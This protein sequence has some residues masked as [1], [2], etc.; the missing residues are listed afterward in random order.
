MALKLGLAILVAGAM[1]VGPSVAQT[2]PTIVGHWHPEDTPQDC[3]TPFE[4]QITPMGYAEETL[5]C[6]FDDVRRD[7][8]QVT[9]NG[10]CH[11]GS[12]RRPMKLVAL[13]DNGRLTLTF[14]GQP[15]WTA[16]KRC[17]PVTGNF[18]PTPQQ[19]KL[20]YTEHSADSATAKAYWADAIEMVAKF[21]PPPVVP[22]TVHTAQFDRYTFAM[23]MGGMLCGMGNH[24]CPMRLYE[25]DK[26][27]GEFSACEQ[28]DEHAVTADFTRFYACEL[29]G[30]GRMLSSLVQ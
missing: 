17:A 4:V 3:G 20:S 23:V 24:G 11:D 6:E 2:Y 8:W 18:Q 14:N 28:L 9:W 12:S 13:E 10:N 29:G 25:G 22:V 30:Q 5:M 27:L 21:D 26:K 19:V 7:G 16:L 1:S 15:G